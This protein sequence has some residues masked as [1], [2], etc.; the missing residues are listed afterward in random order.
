[1]DYIVS[2]ETLRRTTHCRKKF[3]CQN[4]GGKNICAAEDCVGG[5]VLFVTCSEH[6]PCAYRTS[7]GSG[8]TCWCPTRKE[9]HERFKI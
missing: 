6:T 2:D 4:G 9:I 3:A 8:Y 1:M 7:F 5:K